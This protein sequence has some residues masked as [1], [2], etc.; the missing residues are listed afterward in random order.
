MPRSKLSLSLFT[1][2][3]KNGASFTTLLQEQL[4]REE[5]RQG[6]MRHPP[7]PIYFA[8]PFF[9]SVVIN[10][11]NRE[12]V[13]SIEELKAKVLPPTQTAFKK[14]QPIVADKK[15][16][17]SSAEQKQKQ[18]AAATSATSAASSSSAGSLGSGN[19]V[20]PPLPMPQSHSLI[21]AQEH[22]D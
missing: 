9:L 14:A 22:I 5:D 12:G 3:N 20:S 18:P 2:T 21:P 17:S 11:S 15:E 7:I 10:Y 8:D 13:K 19:P 16:S 6:R 4:E 1:R